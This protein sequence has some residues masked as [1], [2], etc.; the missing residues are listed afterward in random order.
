MSKVSKKKAGVIIE[1]DAM[2]KAIRSN[3]T[4]ELLAAYEQ[5]FGKKLEV[6]LPEQTT[7]VRMTKPNK[8][9]SLKTNKVKRRTEPLED[10]SDEDGF[11]DGFEAELDSFSRGRKTGLARSGK[12]LRKS[13]GSGKNA[14]VARPF[15]PPAKQNF[16][17]AKRERDPEVIEADAWDKKAGKCPYTPRKKGVFEMEIVVCRRCRDEFEIS[18]N[19]PGPRDRYMC[20]TCCTTGG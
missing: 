15:E 7:T 18:S 2:E 6:A 8:S 4:P 3:P 13:G 9:N 17:D 14:C 19:W 16:V 10:E 5:F 1:A 20:N 11:D 12:R